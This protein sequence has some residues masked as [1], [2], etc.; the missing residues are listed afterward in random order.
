MTVSHGGTEAGWKDKE[1]PYLATLQRYRQ[2]ERVKIIP[3][4]FMT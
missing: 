1:Q 3:V 2:A 4:T